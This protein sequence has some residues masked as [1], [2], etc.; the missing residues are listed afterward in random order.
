MKLSTLLTAV[1]SA[2]FLLLFMGLSGCDIN[3]YDVEP[4]EKGQE[5]EE[6]ARRNEDDSSENSGYL[7]TLVRAPR[8]AE[9]KTAVITVE[10]QIQQFKALYGE[11]P[12]T[13]EDL[14]EEWGALPELPEGKEYEY[15]PAEGEVLIREK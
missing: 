4:E 7:G 15:D 10:R 3:G 9:E 13:L 11:R 8:S 12:E 6:Q 14:K 5:T 2:F 1:C